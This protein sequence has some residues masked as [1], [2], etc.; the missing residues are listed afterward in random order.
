MNKLKLVTSFLLLLGMALW[1]LS[2]SP[3]GATKLESREGGSG[4]VRAYRLAKPAADLPMAQQRVHRVGLMHLCVTNWG[5]F[6]SQVRELK[7]SKGG[8][9][10]PDPNEEVN[11]P[12]CEYPRDP[13]LTIFFRGD[14]G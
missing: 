8:C 1:C 5:F 2:V 14:C 7:E 4:E 12:S 3:S 6:G 9:M 10:M 11:A 13:T